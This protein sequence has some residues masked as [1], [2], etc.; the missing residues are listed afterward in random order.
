MEKSARVFASKVL[1]TDG[2][3]KFVCFS[4]GAS[5]KGA[6][7]WRKKISKTVNSSLWGRYWCNDSYSHLPLHYF[8]HF[9][10][11]VCHEAWTHNLH[12]SWDDLAIFCLIC[13]KDR[14]AADIYRHLKVSWSQTFLNTQSKKFQE[15]FLSFS[16]LSM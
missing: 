7:E 9:L 13:K 2:V 8:F 5:P 6:V 16:I 14:T 10:S 4:N 11:S 12:G 15:N 1:K 3:F